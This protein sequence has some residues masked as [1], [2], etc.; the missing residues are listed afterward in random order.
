MLANT[1]EIITYFKENYTE[2]WIEY[3]ESKKSIKALWDAINMMGITQSSLS[4]FYADNR[5]NWFSREKYI[6]GLIKIQ[7]IDKI[8]RALNIK[9]IYIEKALPEALQIYEKNENHRYNI[10][11]AIYRKRI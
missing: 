7:N 8:I 11:L 6:C 1:D 3:F 9:D 4:T 5:C 2:I 10:S